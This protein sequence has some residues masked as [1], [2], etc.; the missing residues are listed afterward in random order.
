MKKND[1]SRSDEYL[2]TAFE[3]R[4]QSN[5]L[6]TTSLM[7]RNSHRIAQQRLEP[8]FLQ[9]YSNQNKCILICH[10]LASLLQSVRNSLLL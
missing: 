1:V 8:A 4:I 3:K 5:Y 2:F 9:E 7:D 10:S 6:L